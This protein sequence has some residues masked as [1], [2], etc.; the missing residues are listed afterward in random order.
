[1]RQFETMV[2][3]VPTQNYDIHYG[4]RLQ[5]HQNLL[6][7]TLFSHK[8]GLYTYLCV[9]FL[10]CKQRAQYSVNWPWATCI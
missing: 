1:M 2:V 6:F 3:R 4:S 7:M 8:R 10:F 9:Y 5:A